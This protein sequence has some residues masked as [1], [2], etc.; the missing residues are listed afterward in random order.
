MRLPYC[1]FS[2]ANMG[3]GKQSSKKK[4]KTVLEDKGL[5]EYFLQISLAPRFNTLHSDS[6]VRIHHSANRKMTCGLGVNPIS[7]F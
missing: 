1:D 7:L 4:I 6:E 2:K 3:D 5:K